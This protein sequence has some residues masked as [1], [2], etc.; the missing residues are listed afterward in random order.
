MADCRWQEKGRL[1]QA[2]GL[3]PAKAQ[4]KETEHVLCGSCILL[5]KAQ[6]ALCVC[7]LVIVVVVV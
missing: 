7:L 3:A 5:L 6:P 2:E 1:F 4:V